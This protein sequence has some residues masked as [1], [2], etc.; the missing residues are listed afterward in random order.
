[1]TQ[2]AKTEVQR[3]RKKTPFLVLQEPK[4]GIIPDSLFP[5]NPV[6]SRPTSSTN[7]KSRII[8]SCSFKQPFSR[9]DGMLTIT[10]GGTAL[11]WDVER[12]KRY[13]RFSVTRGGVMAASVNMGGSL[14]ISGGLGC[15]VDVFS[16]GH[17]LT[18]K[19]YGEDMGST[20]PLYND[21][22]EFT[23]EGRPPSFRTMFCSHSGPV[24]ALSFCEE[25]KA[26]SFGH[27]GNALGLDLTTGLVYNRVDYV[28]PINTGS[29]VPDRPFSYVLGLRS[30][31]VFLGDTRDRRPGVEVTKTSPLEKIKVLDDGYT[32]AIA[33]NEEIDL[34]DLRSF[35]SFNSFTSGDGAISSIDVSPS[36]R[37]ILCGTEYGIVKTLDVLREEWSPRPIVKRNDRIS[38]VHLC[39][40]KVCVAS[41]DGN[42]STYKI[43]N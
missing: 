29:S 34:I 10:Q 3:L 30:G 40:N 24:S 8:L 36:G 20:L 7:L 18:D 26:F 14:M 43:K 13:E 23:I 35:G 15:N 41:W 33:N 19:L 1:M 42:L 21:E 27:D 12:M 39:G 22:Y 28:S 2:S 25:S 6:R 16:I 9:A 5:V 37:V 17:D 4:V 32:M 31:R 38:G 11:L